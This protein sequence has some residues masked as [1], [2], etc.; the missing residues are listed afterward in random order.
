MKL[1]APVRFVVGMLLAAGLVEGALYVGVPALV[2]A[3]LPGLA[4]TE[5]GRTVRVGDVSFNPLTL[6]LRVRDIRLYSA[7]GQTVDVALGM[8]DVDVSSAS[9]RKAAPVIES[10][11]LDG[12]QVSLSRAE[13]G[14]L[15]IADI[16]EK[17]AEKPASPEPALYALNNVRLRNAAFA[18]KD[19]AAAQS[20]S[21]TDI[22]LDL[23]FLSTLPS[24]VTIAVQPHLRARVESGELQLEATAKPFDENQ[25]ARLS[26]ELKKLP[27]ALAQPWLPTSAGVTVT[28]GELQTALE[29]EFAQRAVQ[30]DSKGGARVDDKH[31]D[32]IAD[33]NS[34]PLDDAQ[35]R[36]SVSGTVGVDG[37]RAA[38]VQPIQQDQQVS[39]PISIEVPVARLELSQLVLLAP[40][41]SRNQLGRVGLSAD[42][43][44]YG[45]LSAQGQASVSPLVWKGSA[46]LDSL[47]LTSLVKWLP[48]SPVNLLGGVASANAMLACEPVATI[49]P[50]AAADSGNASPVAC[51]VSAASLKVKQLAIQESTGAGGTEPVL[52]QFPS[53]LASVRDFKPGSS[54]PVSFTLDIGLAD[55]ADA[56]HADGQAV[57]S[58]L[59]VD[60]VLRITRF[61][62]T[63][64][65]P[66]LGGVTT[67]RL[68]RGV[69]DLD[70]RLGW[71]QDV[72]DV[73]GKASVTGFRLAPNDKDPSVLKLD[74]FAINGIEAQAGVD[75][76]KRLNI[77]GVKVD[78]L[79]ARIERDNAGRLNWEQLLVTHSPSKAAV[80]N[81]AAT[82]TVTMS[83][84]AKSPSTTDAS[85]VIQVGAIQ[86]ERTNVT[87]SDAAVQPAFDAK[88]TSLKG[89]MSAFSTLGQRRSTLELTGS[90]DGDG[91]LVISGQFDP[92]NPRDYLNISL[93]AR[94]I[95]MTRL[96][97][98]SARYAG[99]NIAKGK[100]STTLNYRIEN[101]ALVADN[102]LFLDQLNFGD[103]VASPDATTLPVRLAVALLKNLKGE[104]DLN[105]P[106][107]GS[108]NDP[109][110]SIGEVVFKALGNIIVKAVSAPFRLVASLFDG[111]E[112]F[113]GSLEFDAGLSQVPQGSQKQLGSLVS[114]LTAKPELELEV[115]GYADLLTDSAGL[116]QLR[117]RADPVG[118]DDIRRLA[119]ERAVAAK[120][121]IVEI[122]PELADRI[123]LV[124]PSREQLGKQAEKPRRAVDFA[125][126]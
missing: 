120:N 65:Q 22:E 54:A 89:Q 44:G 75:G 43:S 122:K 102:S 84:P 66:Y 2:S 26:V 58:P 92:I 6:S 12:L 32:A 73:A 96:S 125:V 86:L 80:P 60:S 30:N 83:A 105:L 117:K 20:L 112:E 57:L 37:F 126:R 52:W 67:A 47:P 62:L 1:P 72:L 63:L 7:D 24:D 11:T 18:W 8:L 79:D 56:L 9:L 114:M 50:V 35:R 71:K 124:A 95:E 90:L 59:S 48:A 78:G 98:Y 16:L 104:I 70:T 27:L 109:Q 46:G 38:L 88:L 25:T 39:Q 99:Y 106:V 118:T 64:L 55:A 77:N 17:L 115:T 33:K 34:R 69:L 101:G 21:V 93:R 68:T 121:A 53:V 31:A 91:L 119:Y 51:V 5:L 13:D 100:L 19:A 108:L 42:V 14:R 29:F 94:G 10:L 123:F 3:M 85:P 116:Q 28:A 82:K 110:F 23:P 36:L 111:E 45:R 87:F 103:A 49:H 76:L 74:S 81:V 15:S 107:K 113:A 40:P 61:P 41:G 97:P 4:R